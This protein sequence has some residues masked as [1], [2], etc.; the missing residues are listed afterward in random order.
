MRRVL[1][2]IYRD[3][4][5]APISGTAIL[6]C[7][8]ATLGCFVTGNLDRGLLFLI[9]AHLWTIQRGPFHG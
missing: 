5:R 1:D 4:I 3:W 8:A 2:L 6:A 9:I 7:H